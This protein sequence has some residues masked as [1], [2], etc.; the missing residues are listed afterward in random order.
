MNRLLRA[1]LIAVLAILGIVALVVYLESPPI[2]LTTLDGIP[3]GATKAQVK[4]LIGEPDKIQ[5]EGAVW[6]YKTS[7]I[8]WPTV[9]VIFGQDDLY[10]EYVYDR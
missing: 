7:F 5:N 9:Y 6:V 3:K 1:L 10:E 2:P 4:Q 8:S